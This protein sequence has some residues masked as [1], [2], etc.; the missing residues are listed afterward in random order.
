MNRHLRNLLNI[1]KVI[2]SNVRGTMI[3][4][5]FYIQIFVNSIRHKN[6]K[7][8]RQLQLHMVQKVRTQVLSAFS[9]PLVIL[10]FNIFPTQTIETVH[11][12]LMSTIFP[13]FKGWNQIVISSRVK[14]HGRN[15]FNA[16]PRRVASQHTGMTDPSRNLMFFF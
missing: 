2:S 15:T 5:Q 13:Q 1:N 16:R 11:S 14:S 9:E 12:L 10:R 7:K 4:E 6:L 8:D 3:N